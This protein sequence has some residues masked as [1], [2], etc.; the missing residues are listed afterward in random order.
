MPIICSASG[1]T[2]TNLTEEFI[3]NNFN[4][5][6]RFASASDCLDLITEHLI[7]FMLVYK[8]VHSEHINRASVIPENLSVGMDS[9]TRI[10]FINDCLHHSM[11][12]L[13]KLV[14]T[15]ACGSEQGHVGL[16]ADPVSFLE[17]DWLFFAGHC[18]VL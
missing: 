2:Q 14:E 7:F 15:I 18:E 4:T 6:F 11:P 10:L 12:N 1:V 17:P 13:W 9:S 8:S 3:A 5:F 16:L